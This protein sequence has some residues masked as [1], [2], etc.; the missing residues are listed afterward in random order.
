MNEKPL[1]W[2]GVKIPLIYLQSSIIRWQKNTRAAATVDS[3]RF[4]RHVCELET[5]VV[6]TKIYAN[7]KL[8]ENISLFVIAV[9]VLYASGLVIYILLLYV[10]GITCRIRIAA[11][12]AAS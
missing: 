6:I 5:E 2:I 11:G 1:S 4:V 12:G 8:R 3:C 9:L 10:L 7:Y